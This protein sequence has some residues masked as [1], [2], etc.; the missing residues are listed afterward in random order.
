MIKN[1]KFE[2]V[3]GDIFKINS[4]IRYVS[5]IDLNGKITAS[6][7]KP[8]LQSLLKKSNKVKFSKH[9]ALRRKMRQEFDKKL[10]KV[11]YV[12]VE[13]EN[14]TQLVIYSKKEDIQTYQLI[15]APNWFIKIPYLLEGMI[16]G[17]IGAIVS[18]L[19]LFL[20][21]NLIHYF[22]SPFLDI[23]NY[24]F[25]TIVLLNFLLGMFLVFLTTLLGHGH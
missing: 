2:Q 10:G 6:E 21:Y 20:L 17:L 18:L 1:Q 23:K 4:K 22:L 9:V 3:I 15:G 8:D 13:R 12:H 19:L 25:I 14:I 7:M 16:H 24:D 5:I 11:N